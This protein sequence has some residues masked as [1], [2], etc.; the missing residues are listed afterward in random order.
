M[1][2]TT[3][4]KTL[5]QW[6]ASLPEG[7]PERIQQRQ[8]RRNFLKLASI[9]PT[10]M[11][12][13][14]CGDTGSPAS[15]VQTSLLEQAPWQTFAAVQNHLF[16]KDADSPGA[17]DFNA[18]LYLKSVLELPGVD[19][20]DKKFIRNG[21]KWIN[22]IANQMFT[23]S[24]HLLDKD[25]KETVLQRIATSSAGENW[26]SLLLLYLFEALLTDPVYGGN[27]DKIGWQWLEHQPGF[28]TPVKD[29]RYYLLT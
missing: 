1:R 6:D 28:P 22:D 16:P 12:L 17:D 14:A 20:E 27:T 23:T 4:R 5:L 21:V 18:T 10:S 7:L 9:L 15:Q 26:L 11:L 19:E 13:A 29:K 2:R 25:N 8:S 3:T 24:F